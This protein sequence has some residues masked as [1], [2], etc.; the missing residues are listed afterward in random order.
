MKRSWVESKRYVGWTKWI[1]RSAANHKPRCF[2]LGKD[3]TGAELKAM[4]LTLACKRLV[5]AGAAGWP[6]DAIKAALDTPG[7]PNVC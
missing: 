4:G 7:I 3:R 6:E 2:Y 1:G 5:A